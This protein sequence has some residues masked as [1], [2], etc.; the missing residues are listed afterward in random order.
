[1]CWFALLIFWYLPKQIKAFKDERRDPLG[2]CNPIS[3]VWP[4]GE[5]AQN[6]CMNGNNPTPPGQSIPD[7]QRRP[8]VPGKMAGR[9]WLATID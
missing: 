4:Q 6:H 8:V 1:M 5:S 2:P 3:P 9:S 7:M